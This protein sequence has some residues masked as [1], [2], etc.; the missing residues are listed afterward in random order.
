M[1][2]PCTAYGVYNAMKAGVKYKLDK[3]SLDG[4]K[5]AIKGIG[6]V[7][8]QLANYVLEDGAT[9]IVADKNPMH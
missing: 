6:K 9:L 2:V 8:Y 4:L 3:D 5:I 7:G 1:E